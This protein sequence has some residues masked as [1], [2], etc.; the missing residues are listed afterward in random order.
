MLT[1]CRFASA[2]TLDQVQ[3][4]DGNHTMLTR[5]RFASAETLDQVQGDDESRSL[6]ER[7]APPPL[8]F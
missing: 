2:E 1:R 8:S 3:G 5:C 6:S 7:S 4:D